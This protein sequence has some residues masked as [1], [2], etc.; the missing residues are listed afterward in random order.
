MLRFFYITTSCQQDG[1]RMGQINKI[2]IQSWKTGYLD[3][4]QK[5]KPRK[6][7]IKPTIQ[8]YQWYKPRISRDFFKPIY[9]ETNLVKLGKILVSPGSV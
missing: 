2:S 7:K 6:A 8:I 4:S 1:S 9:H 5:N 3:P